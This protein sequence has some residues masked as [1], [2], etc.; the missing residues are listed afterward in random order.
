MLRFNVIL[1]LLLLQSAAPPLPPIPSEV[2]KVIS[3][4][5][6]K[7][8]PK[9][10][11]L[12]KTIRPLANL[13]AKGEGS[14]NSVNRGGSGDTPGGAR[15]VIGKDLTQTTLRELQHYQATGRVFAVG[16]YQFLPRTLKMAIKNSGINC[17]LRFTP[18]TQDY[19]LAALLQ[20][21]RPAIASFIQGKSTSI[22]YALDELS[23]EWSSIGWRGS[24]S[25]Y[26]GMAST[27][28]QEARAVLAKAR[29][30]FLADIDE[31]VVSGV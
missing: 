9:N 2:P 16:R 14:W 6:V 18:E 11:S 15:S 7:P 30:Q 26:G 21:K 24:R 20:H 13:I 3:K 12:V 19:L 31:G 28:R 4:T 27:S 1:P 25:Y 17:E 22:D 5:P 23:R 8:K 29:D 10:F